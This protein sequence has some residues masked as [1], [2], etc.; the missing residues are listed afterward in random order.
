MFLLPIRREGLR[1]LSVKAGNDFTL[2]LAS[3]WLF[4]DVHISVAI[5]LVAL[6]DRAILILD[7]NDR[8]GLKNP[9]GLYAPLV[10]PGCDRVLETLS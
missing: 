4:I 3:V 2:P 7:W 1:W 10:T 8:D 5:A 6:I 9:K